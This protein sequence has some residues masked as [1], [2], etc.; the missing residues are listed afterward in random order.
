MFVQQLISCVSPQ[1]LCKVCSTC[2]SSSVASCGPA[3][4]GDHPALLACAWAETVLVIPPNVA[5]QKK[6]LDREYETGG[7]RPLLP[8]PAADGGSGRGPRRSWPRRRWPCR[9]PARG[10]RRQAGAGSG[11]AASSSRRND[12]PGPR[13]GSSAGQRER[14][15]ASGKAAAPLEAL[16]AP[17]A[18][19]AVAAQPRA[20]RCAL[21]HPATCC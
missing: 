13:G 1:D 19:T 16:P 20:L 10:A 15:S 3:C 4:V 9:Q 5:L 11:A 2:L 21:A 14:P 12:D 18:T 17:P 6:L 7:E 8:S